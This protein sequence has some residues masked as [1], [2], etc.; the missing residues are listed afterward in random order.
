MEDEIT[1]VVVGHGWVGMIG[2][3]SIFY[4]VQALEIKDPGD[5]TS[6]LLELARTKNY[7]APS[8]EN[9]YGEALLR[10]YHRHLGLPVEDEIGVPEILILGPGCSNCDELKSRVI[11]AAAEIS[12]PAD[13]RHVKDPAEIGKYGLVP[14][15]A[16]VINNELKSSGSVP[17]VDKLKSILKSI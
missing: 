8:S 16:L 14:T 6:K 11:T 7:I 12:L 3:K 17:T 9:E 10:E 4:E 2:L 13:I 15:P 5:L 1:R